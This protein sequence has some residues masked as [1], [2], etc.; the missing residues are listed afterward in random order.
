V[1]NMRKR[2]KR[3]AKEARSAGVVLRQRDGSVRVFD[4]MDVLKALYLA[5]VDLVRGE[6]HGSEVHD[7][8]RNATP[9]TRAAF[10]A[11]YGSI[12]RELHVIAPSEDG[13]WV[14]IR[15]LSAD[16]KVTVERLDGD[17]EE[18]ERIREAAKNPAS[19]AGNRLTSPLGG[20]F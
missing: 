19:F 12:A 6:H 5:E 1:G 7:A 15:R 4:T 8:V 18:A 16:G 9:E 20:G 2:I 3:V 11:Q 17:S 14:E 13:G 10:E